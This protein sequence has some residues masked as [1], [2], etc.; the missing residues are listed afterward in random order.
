MELIKK[1]PKFRINPLVGIDLRNGV[2]QRYVWTSS[3]SEAFRQLNEHL[4]AHFR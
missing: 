3:N 1:A 4:S 2:P